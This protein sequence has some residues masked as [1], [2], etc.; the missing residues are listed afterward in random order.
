MPRR[1]EEPANSLSFR[2]LAIEPR[3]SDS[4]SVDFVS[5]ILGDLYGTE[6]P[7]ALTYKPESQPE[8]EPRKQQ[9][10][11]LPLNGDHEPFKK[12]LIFNKERFWS[13][14]GGGAFYD[15][16][17]RGAHQGEIHRVKALQSI[18]P[19]HTQVP[20]KRLRRFEPCGLS[21]CP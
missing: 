19:D 17:G 7:Q 6:V 15:E 20:G 10:N 12:C 9:T 3:R 14:R 13:K 5:R 2:E 18:M 8:H 16:R 1:A 11:A 4:E 21:N